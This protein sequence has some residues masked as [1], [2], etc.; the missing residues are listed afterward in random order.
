MFAMFGLR[1]SRYVIFGQPGS[2]PVQLAG[3]AGPVIFDRA[4]PNR[5]ANNGRGA[6]PADA[7]IR[8]GMQAAWQIGRRPNDVVVHFSNWATSQFWS[9][10]NVTLRRINGEWIV[11]EIRLGSVT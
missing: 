10:A 5:L 4:L 7:M 3:F 2:R 6:I 11:V 9:T 1:G 8:G